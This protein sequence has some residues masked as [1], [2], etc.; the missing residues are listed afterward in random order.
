M[1]TAMFKTWMSALLL[2]VLAGCASISKPPPEGYGICSTDPG[3][4]ACEIE[5][6]QR[7]NTP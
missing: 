3:S 2:G 5:Q 1:V 4:H 6:Y 7:V